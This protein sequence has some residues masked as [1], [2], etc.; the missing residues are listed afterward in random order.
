[1]NKQTKREQ[2]KKNVPQTIDDIFKEFRERY[3]E[4]R[5]IGHIEGINYLVQLNGCGY[6]RDSKKIFAWYKPIDNESNELTQILSKD[7]L[8]VEEFP[9]VFE[10][11]SVTYRMARSM[12]L[13]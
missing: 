11:H 5:P 2:T 10:G 13:L 4:G 12:R 7:G 9:Q 6:S 8:G 1:M 3:F